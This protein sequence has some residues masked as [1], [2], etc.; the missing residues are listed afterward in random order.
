MEALARA[1]VVP[2]CP[3]MAAGESETCKIHATARRVDDAHAGRTC[4]RCRRQIKVGQWITAAS[5]DAAEP[6]HVSCKARGDD[7]P[8][9]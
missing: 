1:C 4:R 8:G 2:N 6:A 3:A 7:E 5:F 9:D